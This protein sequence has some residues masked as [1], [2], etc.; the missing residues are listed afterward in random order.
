[1]KDHQREGVSFLQSNYFKKVT[2]GVL[3]ADDMGLGKTLQILYFLE[4]VAHHQRKMKPVLIICPSSLIENWKDEYSKFFKQL[5]FNINVLTG[6]KINL[7]NDIS[8]IKQSEIGNIP[9]IITTYET[10]RINALKFCAIEWGV[11]IL[12]EAQKIKNPNA[13]VTH[14]TKALET[15]FKIALTG[16]P[17]ENSLNDLW[18]IMD[19]CVPGILGSILEFNKKLRLSDFNPREAI[20]N[21]FIRRL[22]K[23]VAKDLPVKKELKIKEKMFGEQLNLYESTLS[24]LQVLKDNDLLKGSV[25]LRAIHELRN[26]VDHP[27]LENDNLSFIEEDL[28]SSAKMKITFDLL[29]EIK[30][31]DEKVIVFTDKRKMQYILKQ[32]IQ[33]IFNLDVNI[34]NGDVPSLSNENSTK[35]SRQKLVDDF[36]SKE[37]FNIIIMSPIAAGFGLNVTSANHV[38]HYTRHWNPAKEQQATDRAYRIGQEKDVSVYYPISIINDEINSFDEIIDRMLERKKKIS[39]DIMFPS[40][41]IEITNEEIIKEII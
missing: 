26:I 27:L 19:F 18:C 38:I 40:E 21:F 3:L 4:S 34:V 41:K 39:E 33:N 11:V 9:L 36:Q 24:Q 28:F 17:V 2:P 7:L 14:S 35:L 15:E 30:R 5:S 20:E 37:G 29:K 1:L 8:K 31:K 12:D 10:L 13:L 22:K 25:V 23:D 16:T 6:R 32:A